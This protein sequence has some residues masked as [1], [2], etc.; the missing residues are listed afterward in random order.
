[1]VYKVHNITRS[2]RHFPVFHLTNNNTGCHVTMKQFNST[3][4]YVTI[5][6]V[7]KDCKAKFKI[8][9]KMEICVMKLVR[10]SPRIRLDLTKEETFIS[11]SYIVSAVT[12]GHSCGNMIEKEMNLECKSFT[13]NY[14]LNHADLEASGGD[15]YNIMFDYVVS[16]YGSASLISNWSKPSKVEQFIKRAK[17]NIRSPFPEIEPDFIS[18]EPITPN[19][20]SKYIFASDVTHFENEKVLK[21]VNNNKN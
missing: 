16:K 3:K 6:C 5:M 15:I 9:P 14:V 4:D 1:M 2:N 7:E 10:N 17:Q 8:T 12:T 13:K 19:H 20:K 21:S 18:V 11:S